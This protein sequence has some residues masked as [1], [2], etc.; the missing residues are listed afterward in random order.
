M[1]LLSALLVAL[2]GAWQEA[3]L[4]QELPAATRGTVK[5]RSRVFNPFEVGQSRLTINPF[6]V[7]TLTEA[8][9]PA[10]PAGSVDGPAVIGPAASATNSVI[11][12]EDGFATNAVRPPFRPPVRSPFR[13]PPRPPF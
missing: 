6:G 10:P 5:V 12:P 7:F 9:S 1:H 13:P 8:P 4:A 3:A 2:A 11:G